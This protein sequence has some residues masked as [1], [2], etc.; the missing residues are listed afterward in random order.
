MRPRKGIGRRAV[1]A[2]ALGAVAACAPVPEAQ[3]TP[4]SPR[5][6][7]PEPGRT[8]APSER[9]IEQWSGELLAAAGS[10]NAEEAA[11]LLGL[12]ADVEVRDEEGRS[13]LML[14]VLGDH[15]AVAEVLVERGA[16]PDALD[17]AG[18]TPWVNCGV[19]G[20]VAMMQAL[21]P[22]GPDLAIPNRRGGSPLHPA[23]ERGHV[24]YVWEVLAATDIEAVIDRVNYNGWT[25]MLEAVA[26]GDGSEPYQEIV[27]LLL[28]AG[29][30]TTIRDRHGR[31]AY[32]HARDRGYQ[33]IEELLR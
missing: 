20:S 31:T 12:G 11:R 7:A 27:A 2:A 5:Y 15:A 29:A 1:M 17:D 18:D 16:D 25:A 30:D 6:G 13:P 3:E 21:L 32:E 26:L 10:G 14:A 4:S 22:A 9:G 33:V 19:T 8:S 28:E 23:S 24:D